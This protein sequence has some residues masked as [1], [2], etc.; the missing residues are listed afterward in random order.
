MNRRFLTS[1]SLFSATLL[2]SA[3][4]TLP[5][6]LVSSDPHL[7]T[8]YTRWDPD[9]SGGQDLRLGGVIA[10]VTNLETV[11]RI[12]VVNLPINSDGKPDINRE[13]SGRFVGYIDG[14][15]DPVSATQG[16][17]VTFLGNNHGVEHAKVGEYDYRFPVMDIKSY[18]LW[19][20]EEQVIFHDDFGPARYSCRSLYC[21]DIT[22]GTR[23]G[24]VIQQ[25]K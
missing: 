3:C 25:V 13:P 11:T 20:I 12:E 24:K 10:S 8:D 23:Q 16:R 5:D 19:R 22:R 21:R 6:N 18:H 15:I 4:T 7:L 14:F 17:L 1:I 2:L 9:A